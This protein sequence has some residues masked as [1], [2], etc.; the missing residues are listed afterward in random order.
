LNGL[1]P[2]EMEEKE[3]HFDADFSKLAYSG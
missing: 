1:T 3:K 2:S